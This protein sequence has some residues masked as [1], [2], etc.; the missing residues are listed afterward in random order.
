M[1]RPPSPDPVAEASASQEPLL[2]LLGGDDPAV[3]Q[4][5]TPATWR[6]LV[7]EAGARVAERPEPEEWSVLECLGH[8][9]DAEIVSAGRY[10]WSVAH[11]EPPLIGYDQDL[12]VDRLHHGQDDP[13][14]LLVL[15]DALRQA[16]LA[17]WSRSTEQ[18]RARVGM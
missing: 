7:A 12:W 17:M 3:V 1:E 5:A 13:A 8:A 6:S 10:R 11:D 18:E 15:F 4:A 16:N 2:A 14:E 9:A